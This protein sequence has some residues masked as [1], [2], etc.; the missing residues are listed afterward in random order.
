[1]S[2]EIKLTSEERKCHFVI[3]H[4]NIFAGVIFHGNGCH[5]VSFHKDINNK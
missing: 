4:K 2:R 3:I 5:K 1:M